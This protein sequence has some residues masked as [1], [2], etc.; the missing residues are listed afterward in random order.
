MK[1]DGSGRDKGPA[2]QGTTQQWRQT[3]NAAWQLFLEIALPPSSGTVRVYLDSSRL[4]MQPSAGIIVFVLTALSSIWNLGFLPLA[5]SSTDGRQLPAYLCNLARLP[6]NPTTL[7]GFIALFQ[8]PTNPGPNPQVQDGTYRTTGHPLAAP[9]GTVLETQQLM[10]SWHSGAVQNTRITDTNNPIQISVRGIVS[11][12]TSTTVTPVP[13]GQL[14]SGALHALDV[15]STPNG[16]FD[17][18]TLLDGA[19]IYASLN[20]SDVN[21]VGSFDNGYLTDQ[22]QAPSSSQGADLTV[23]S[24][25]EEYGQLF[26]KMMEERIATPAKYSCFPLMALRFCQYIRFREERMPAAED[27]ELTEEQI[28]LIAREWDAADCASTMAMRN[29]MSLSTFRDWANAI[30]FLQLLQHAL[31]TGEFDAKRKHLYSDCLICR[32]RLLHKSTCI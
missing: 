6:E 5:L 13:A 31:A 3:L 16:A 30:G 8:L 12:V 23:R 28:R 9:L 10:A 26:L 14:V 24:A 29:T 25:D 17:P 19:I 22:Q 15:R 11:S 1:L 7:G 32:W 18:N 21:R 27:A 2:A 4:E 20:T